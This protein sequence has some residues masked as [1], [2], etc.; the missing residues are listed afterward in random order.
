MQDCDQHVSG[1]MQ[2]GNHASSANKE[3]TRHKKALYTILPFE[4]YTDQM[5]TDTG[6][7]LTMHAV[8]TS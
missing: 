1:H 8:S 2:Q 7:R 3:V 5:F 4:V 6:Q